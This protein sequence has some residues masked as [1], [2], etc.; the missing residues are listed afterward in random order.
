MWKKIYERN[1]FEH[2]FPK[3]RYYHDDLASSDAEEE[4]S[5]EDHS[6]L[7]GSRKDYETS[8][9]HVSRTDEKSTTHAALINLIK[10]LCKKLKSDWC[11]TSGVEDCWCS[12]SLV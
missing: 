8:G 7:S 5:G 2:C 3:V 11:Q 12:R 4:Q 6:L 10:G 1:N 9:H